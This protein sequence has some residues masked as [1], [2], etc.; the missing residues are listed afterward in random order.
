MSDE[1]EIANLLFEYAARIDAGDFA[2]VAELFRDGRILTEFGEVVGYEAVLDMYRSSTRLYQDGT[3]RTRHITTN[4]AIRVEGDRARCNSTFT[5]MQSLE[6]FPLQAIICGR[7]QD[8]LVRDAGSWRFEQ[9]RMLPDLLGDL[10]RHLLFD[11]ADA[12][13]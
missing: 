3:P 2:G 12:G 8:A 9:R 6:D 1:T 13:A 4:L 10:S 5:V 7:Y 11:L